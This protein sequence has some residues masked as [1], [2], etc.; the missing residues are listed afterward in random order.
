MSS[1]LIC[2]RIKEI[3]ENK[4]PYFV[5]EMETGYVVI[6]DFQF[7]KGYALLLCKHHVGELHELDRNIRLK[8]LEEMSLLAEAVWNCN[9]PKLLNY[10]LLGNAEPHLHWHIFPRYEDDP[11][12]RGPG[13]QIPRELRYAEEC[14]P[15]EANLNEYREKL[16][17]ELNRLAGWH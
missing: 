4:N 11:N 15:S 2:T 13:W 9:K 7:F 12:P 5:K 6:G 3:A 10:E 1:C 14:R 8:F 16:L 17:N